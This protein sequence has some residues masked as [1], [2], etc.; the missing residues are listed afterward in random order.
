M[1]DKKEK[2]QQSANLKKVEGLVEMKLRRTF[3]WKAE[4]SKGEK[5]FLTK[6]P[7]KNKELLSDVKF[8]FEVHEKTHYAKLRISKVRGDLNAHYYYKIVFKKFFS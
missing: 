3:I 1:K 4:P 7:D 5:M 2:R 6:K 8:I